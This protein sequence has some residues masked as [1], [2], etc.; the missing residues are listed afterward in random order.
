MKLKTVVLSP[1]LSY[2]RRLLIGF[3]ITGGFLGVFAGAAF[4]PWALGRLLCWLTNVHT[5]FMGAWAAGTL[6]IVFF[7]LVPILVKSSETPEV[8]R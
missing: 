7:V 5:D 8:D 2:F 3:V 1:M 6:F 4:V